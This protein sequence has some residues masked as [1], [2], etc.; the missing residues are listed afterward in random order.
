MVLPVDCSLPLFYTC[1]FLRRGTVVCEIWI[2][3]TCEGRSAGR[4][5]LHLC[6]K[7]EKEIRTIT[8]ATGV[9]SAV[10]G[11]LTTV[12]VSL[13]YMVVEIDFLIVDMSPFDQIFGDPSTE[14]LQGVIGIGKRTVR[15]TIADHRVKLP[16]HAN[17]S[18]EK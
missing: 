18:L 15:L 8:V 12:P 17:Y 6:I 9:K 10:V 11:I 5:H 3:D 16:L 1:S 7:P 2:Y 13:E 14:D 4:N